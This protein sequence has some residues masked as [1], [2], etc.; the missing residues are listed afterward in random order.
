MMNDADIQVSEGQ[1]RFILEIP[2]YRLHK[3]VEVV[4]FQDG[5]NGYRFQHTL[6]SPERESGLD[7][8]GLGTTEYSAADSLL[9]QLTKRFE[10]PENEL[11]RNYLHSIM[12]K[13]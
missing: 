13:L 9:R 5:I 6:P 4:F 1:A 8:M 7:I 2:G 11:E 3:P 12:S 10:S